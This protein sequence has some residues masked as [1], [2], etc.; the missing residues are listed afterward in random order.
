MVTMATKYLT[1]E[2]IVFFCEGG[3]QRVQIKRNTRKASNSMISR[4]EKNSKIKVDNQRVVLFC[5][6]KQWLRR[7]D[8]QVWRQ[9]FFAWLIWVYEQELTS[10]PTSHKKRKNQSVKR[11]RKR[12]HQLPKSTRRFHRKYLGPKRYGN[13]EQWEPEKFRLTLVSNWRSRKGQNWLERC[14]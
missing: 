4:G 3:L 9:E 11:T 8:S 13:T 12:H 10:C 14:A 6:F 7:R 2:L 5:G 1:S